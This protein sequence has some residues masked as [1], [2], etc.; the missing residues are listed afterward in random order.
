MESGKWKMENIKTFLD[1]PFST[2]HFPFF[3]LRL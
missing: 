1:F 3:A 2:F